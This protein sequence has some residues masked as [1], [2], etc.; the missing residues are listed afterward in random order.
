MLVVDSA[1]HSILCTPHST[2][3][4]QR[5]GTMNPVNQVL[6]FS[7]VHDISLIKQWLSLPSHT[8]MYRS[9]HTYQPYH[10]C[11]PVLAA[12]QFTL[13]FDGFISFFTAIDPLG[14]D[15]GSYRFQQSASLLRQPVGTALPFSGTSLRQPTASNSEIVE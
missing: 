5:N 12:N 2:S 8:R 9:P 13:L 14:T 3:I 10:H 7:C 11:T 15:P 6:F 4:Q 1:N